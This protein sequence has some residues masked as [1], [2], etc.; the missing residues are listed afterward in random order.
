MP[1]TVACTVLPDQGGFRIDIN[2]NGDTHPN[3]NVK[4][5]RVVTGLPD[6][7]VRP[8]YAPSSTAVVAGE[9]LTLPGRDGSGASTPDNAALDITG[10]ISLRAEVSPAVWTGAS[11][12][13]VIAKWTATG[14]QISYRLSINPSG[15]VQI[16]WSADGST[17]TGLDSIAIAGTV[18]GGRLAIRADLDVNNGAGGRTATFYTAPSIAGPWTLFD[19]QTAAGVTS[20]FS[21]TSGVEVGLNTTGVAVP[22]N[23]TIHAAAIYNSVGTAVAN[24]NFTIQDNRDT[25]FVDDAGRTWTVNGSAVILGL[26]PGGAGTSDFHVTNCGQLILWDFEAPMDVP[27][28]YK[29]TDDPYGDTVTSSSCVFP[30][31]GSPWLKDPLRP[32]NNIKL[33]DCRTDCPA[34]DDVVWIGHEQ[35]QYTAV[36][37]Q[38]DVIGKRRPVSVSNLRKDAVTVVHFATLTCAARDAMLALTAPGTPLFM[39]KFDAICWPDRYLDL[40]D[41][42]VIP[43]SRDLRRT[44]RLHTL[45]A[46]VVDA[47]AG[48]TCCV[49]GTTWCEMCACAE[50]WTAFDALALTGV[51]VLHGEAVEC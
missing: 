12:Q 49:T 46:V 33:A 18:S 5:Q 10:D 7:L 20:I 23:G 16:A 39:P 17:T 48:P 14:N 26:T 1:G 29:V 11:Y 45:P 35:E 6:T 41:H 15:G 2:W 42:A 4:V 32:C 9:G 21:S 22:F 24:P 50:T 40:G 43:L 30:S 37:A 31:G 27:V 51:Q 36:S 3:A 13:A 19:T 28:S 8:A 44:E 34:E 25:S 47:P 38:F